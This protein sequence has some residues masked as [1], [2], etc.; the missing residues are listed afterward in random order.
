MDELLWE[1]LPLLKERL[2]EPPEKLLERLLLPE[3]KERLELLELLEKPLE[4]ER[5]E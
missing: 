4:E 3:E 2:E 5:G 1:E